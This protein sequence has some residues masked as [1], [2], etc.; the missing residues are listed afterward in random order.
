MQAEL[1]TDADEAV[2]DREHE[3]KGNENGRVIDGIVN[4]RAY[5]AKDLKI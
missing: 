1:M 4:G 3:R 2:N 5:A